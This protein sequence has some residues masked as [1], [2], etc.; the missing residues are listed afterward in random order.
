MP[1]DLRHEWEH[2][3]GIVIHRSGHWQ[4][5]PNDALG[6]DL[7]IIAGPIIVVAEKPAMAM[8][9]SVNSFKP[10]VFSDEHKP[11]MRCCTDVLSMFLNI[12]SLSVEQIQ[13]KEPQP[14]KGVGHVP[15]Q[16][17]Q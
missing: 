3:K 14:E 8:I 6:E 17:Q 15:A 9:L 4:P 10:D 13:L 11:F 7:D 12:V 1:S 5:S 2:G 16:R